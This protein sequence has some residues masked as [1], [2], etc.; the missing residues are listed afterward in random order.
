[1]V[2]SIFLHYFIFLVEN[3]NISTNNVIFSVEAAKGTRDDIL[4]T[5]TSCGSL[6]HKICMF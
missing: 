4:G 6:G 3:F 5:W 2:F 1:M